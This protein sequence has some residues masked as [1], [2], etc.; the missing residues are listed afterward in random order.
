[1]TPEQL[2]ELEALTRNALPEEVSD[3]LPTIHGRVPAPPKKPVDKQVPNDDAKVSVP[4]AS[5]SR[6]HATQEGVVYKAGSTAPAERIKWP[7]PQMEVG[8]WI[9]VHD[10]KKFQRAR[11]AAS[12]YG[13]RTGKQFTCQTDQ[14]GAL[15]VTRR[16]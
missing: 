5:K 13:S 16:K 12:A 6:T 4:K 9:A 2:A 15:I 7:F 3:D 1:M 10:V 14:D 11:L 8:H